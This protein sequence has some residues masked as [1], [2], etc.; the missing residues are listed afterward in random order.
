MVVL[1]SANRRSQS[2]LPSFASQQATTSKRRSLRPLAQTRPSNTAGVERPVQSVRQIRFSPSRDQVEM[3]PFSSEV[4]LPEGP[5]QP[6]HSPAAAGLDSL[7]RT[8]SNTARGS[9]DRLVIVVSSSVLFA[10]PPI[11]GSEVG[12]FKSN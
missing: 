11:L 4:L 5:R 3:R 10:Q 1:Y 2:F 6:G 9:V 8:A 7:T 12:R